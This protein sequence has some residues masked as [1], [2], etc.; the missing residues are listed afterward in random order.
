MT[1]RVLVFVSLVAL[2]ACAGGDASDRSAPDTTH[3]TSPTAVVPATTVA[4][5][6]FHGSVAIID[7]AGRARM[8]YSWRPGCPV[9]LDE[10]RL[11]T[12]DHWGYDGAEHQGELVVHADHAEGVVSAFRALFAARFPIER[13]ELVDAYGGDDHASTLANNTSGFNCRWSSAGR[14]HGPNMPSDVPSTSIR[15]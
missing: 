3:R 2:T 7:A 15:V 5:P 6:T 10:L 9:S 12:V 11:L 13:M 1:A 8:P 4:G 14:A